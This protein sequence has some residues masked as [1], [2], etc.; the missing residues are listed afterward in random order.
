MNNR[1]QD[2]V[3]SV[4]RVSPGA[5]SGLTAS[6]ISQAQQSSPGN[7]SQQNAVSM[8]LWRRIAALKSATPQQALET[9]RM[10]M[11]A[12]AS[13]KNAC[14]ELE[15]GLT[16]LKNDP[17]LLKAL[18]KVAD[19]P[20]A[21]INQL[22]KLTDN[23]V[24]LGQSALGVSQGAGGIVSGQ[25]SNKAAAEASL[26]I[27]ELATQLNRLKDFARL[28]NLVLEGITEEI[29][30]MNKESDVARQASAALI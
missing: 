27:E 22:K 1:Y 21:M 14:A 23:M 24:T 10:I 11:E 25:Q 12:I 15:K 2:T 17:A 20:D 30:S 5:L 9:Y 3:G 4:R 28:E 6:L 8:E 18:Q 16:L 13:D 29:S 26:E 7:A 19:V